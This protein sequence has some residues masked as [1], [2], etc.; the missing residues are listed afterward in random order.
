MEG[1]SE[2]LIQA[3]VDEVYNYVRD[4]TRHTEWNY[5]PTAITKVT[6]GPL[7][8]GTVFRTEERPA[9]TAPW[10]MR[11]VMAPLMLKLVGF[12]GYTEAEITALEPGRR[13]AWTA[14]APLKGGAI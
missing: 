11:K 10:I 6:D 9:G 8:V 2:I 3:P 13:L 4:F 5:Q 1:E 7:D 12:Q 14:A